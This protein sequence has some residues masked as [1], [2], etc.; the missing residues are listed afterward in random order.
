[1][2]IYRW[3]VRPILFGFDPERVHEAT[4]R[5]CQA[6]ARAGFFLQGPRSVFGYEDARLR[7]SVAKV[8]PVAECGL[9]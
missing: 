6:T 4:L 1:M 5:V 2:S 3:C 9:P 7:V 8:S